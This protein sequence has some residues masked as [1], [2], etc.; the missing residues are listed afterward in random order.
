MLLEALIR[1]KEEAEK[2]VAK[3]PFSPL[4]A[5][6]HED[7]ADARGAIYDESFALEIMELLGDEFANEGRWHEWPKVEEE[8]RNTMD[9]CK[10]DY[11]ECI[12]LMGN[13]K[14]RLENTDT[15]QPFS[16]DEESS[17]PSLADRV[18]INHEVLSEL[19]KQPK[20]KPEEEL[21]LAP[22]TIDKGED[23]SI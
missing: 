17:L 18:Q 11:A 1:G 2:P 10:E 12:D 6:R 5:V 22:V 13:I 21:E 19:E 16:M 20:C 15:N 9:K 4:G 8:I 7:P 23:Y 3:G 14:V